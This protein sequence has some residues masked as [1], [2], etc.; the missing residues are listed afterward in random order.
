MEQGNTSDGFRSEMDTGM[1][2]TMTNDF[3]ENLKR[4]LPFKSQ[5]EWVNVCMC[6]VT[7]IIHYVKKPSPTQDVCQMTAKEMSTPNNPVSTCM[8]ITTKP[9]SQQ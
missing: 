3:K 2:G 4:W 9:S 7:I 6:V 8:T 1:N 5:K